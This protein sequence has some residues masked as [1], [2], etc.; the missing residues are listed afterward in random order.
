MKH[1]H[2]AMVLFAMTAV[3]TASPPSAAF[4]RAPLT[5][6]VPKYWSGTSCR[7]GVST[8]L[9]GS[10][11]GY[12][13]LKM[14][15]SGST[16]TV[17]R[18]VNLDYPGG[19]IYDQDAAIG[20]LFDSTH[21]EPGSNVTITAEAWDLAGNYYGPMSASAPVRNT[22]L[23]G[24]H[25]FTFL[26]S[27]PS[28]SQAT[29][30][31]ETAL[32]T[33]VSTNGGGRFSKVKR[34]GP[35]LTKSAWL[36]DLKQ[37]NFVYISTHGSVGV[38]EMEN[39]DGI[40]D[41]GGGGDDH[42]SVLMSSVG[43]SFTVSTYPP[44]NPSA[45]SPPHFV[46][47]DACDVFTT[48]FSWT[49]YPK[50]NLY[51]GTGIPSATNVFTAGWKT[52]MKV[53]DTSLIAS[54]LMSKLLNGWPAQMSLIKTVQDLQASN[55]KNFAGDLVDLSMLGSHGDPYMKLAGIYTGDASQNVLWYKLWS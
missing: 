33:S 17:S 37:A 48:P 44:F 52:K 20:A 8:A 29:P 5:L 13:R 36:N 51:D 15:L 16:D 23:L 21:F 31:I 10:R 2:S 28:G 49:L 34:L 14:T 30:A 27:S 43:S 12:T 42:K 53:N 7:T 9:F 4:V 22:A 32:G 45:V 18:V 1:I 38:Y 39:G 46:F 41:Q 19:Y 11:I 26:G 50:Y 54:T 40:M 6:K 25:S 35:S 47:I 24:N 55:V 3:G